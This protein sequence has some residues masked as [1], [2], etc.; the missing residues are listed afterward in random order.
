MMISKSVK[1]VFATEQNDTHQVLAWARARAKVMHQTVQ[2]SRICRT[3]DPR[4][5]GLKSSR[6]AQGP[7]NE[8]QSADEL[9]R[10][11]RMLWR[12]TSCWARVTASAVVRPWPAC[13]TSETRYRGG[14]STLRRTSYLVLFHLVLILV[15]NVPHVVV[16][17]RVRILWDDFDPV[18]ALR[19]RTVVL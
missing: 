16:L 19:R 7:L 5:Q 10:G 13:R 1:S 15:V 4:F 17:I 18:A 11:W 3:R 12:L 14:Y 8:F 2:I 6:H 9:V